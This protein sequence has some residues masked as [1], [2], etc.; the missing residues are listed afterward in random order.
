MKNIALTVATL[1]LPLFSYAQ[2]PGFMILYDKYTGRDGFTTIDMSGEMFRAVTSGNTRTIEDG[3]VERIIIIV[4]ETDQ[5][6]FR[7]DVEQ[8]FAAGEYDRVSTVRNGGQKVE[9]Y[10]MKGDG[11]YREFLMN[12]T[13]STEHVIMLVTGN[14]LTINSV[15]EITGNA[16]AS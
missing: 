12:I 4:A 13:G 10:L 6:A 3:E 7:S 1:L 14:G 15:R 2:S 5:D 9:F 11:N 8:M 16:A